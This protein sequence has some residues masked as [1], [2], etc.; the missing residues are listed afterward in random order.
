MFDP[1]S[2]PTSI[3]ICDDP[4]PSTPGS[5]ASRSLNWSTSATVL[6]SSYPLNCG[7]I[8]N[9]IKFSVLS[10]K[11]C[12][13]RFHS[14]RANNAPPVS[15]SNVNATCPATRYFRNR[16]WPGPADVVQ[17][18]RRFGQQQISKL[19]ACNQQHQRHHRKQRHQGRPGIPLDRR[20]PLRPGRQHN[21][22]V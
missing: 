1:I 12:F 2:V 22:L 16:T 3:G 13:R 9:V 6:A 4:T 15:N 10:P 8:E 18:C 21:L 11:F 14:V 20:P 5:T 7:E 19:R 17:P